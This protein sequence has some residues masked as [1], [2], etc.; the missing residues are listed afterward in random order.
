MIKRILFAFCGL[1]GVIILVLLVNTLRLES[2]QADFP[3]LPKY[4]VPE[5]ALVHLSE[6]IRFP[7]IS[8]DDST[9]F[10][11]LPFDAFLDFLKRTYPLCDSLLN[12]TLINQYGLLY[13][14]QGQ[15][16]SLKPILLTAHYDVVPV[17]TSYAGRWTESPFSGK[18]DDQY[19][20]GRGTMDDKL[21][22]IGILEAT[23]ALLG[24]GYVPDRSIYL[25]FGFDEE[26]S[27]VNGAAKIADYFADHQIRFAYVMDEGLLIARELVPGI[28]KD[29]ALVGLS[30]KGFLS[31]KLSVVKEGGHASM[32]QSET[33]ID[34]LATAVLNLRRHQPKARISE[35]VERFVEFIGPEMPFLQRM[36]FANRSLFEGLILKIYEGTPAGN[37]LVRTTTA[38]TVFSA[39]GKANVL[40]GTASAMVNFRI[41][42]NETLE[43]LLDHI[44]KTIN[45]PRVEVMIAGPAV[46]PS[47]VSSTE[48]QGFH[49][50]EKT[51]GQI[52]PDVLVAASLVTAGTDGRHYTS[53][54][55][56]VYRFSPQTATA[57]DLLRLHGRNE[58]ISKE[59]F[60]DCVRFYR[61]LIVNVNP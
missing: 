2:K 51:L 30:E 53:V 23:E 29:V 43:G 8:T 5:S 33:V 31:V 24:E 9:H 18:I 38:P 49:T 48:S 59:G 60:K 37:S 10:N 42:P 52:Y 40:P 14:W 3:P 36:V 54:A 6:A 13:H 21:G 4:P 55:D 20:W 39:G 25:A 34:I 46:E 35:P 44:K 41:L 47:P 61:Q 15:E 45:D 50:I 1:I 17:D 12:K 22:V 56:D 26:I 57:E 7:T 16:A 58:R 32:P 11:P 19:I 27:G 28:S